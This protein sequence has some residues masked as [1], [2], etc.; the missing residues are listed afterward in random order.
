MFSTV[1]CLVSIASLVSLSEL[2]S[3]FY[4]IVVRYEN[5]VYSICC[6]EVFLRS[7]T[8]PKV[9]YEQGR[10]ASCDVQVMVNVVYDM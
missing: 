5:R 6:F 7:F 1:N 10:G 2:L 3:F 8:A 9:E 4:H